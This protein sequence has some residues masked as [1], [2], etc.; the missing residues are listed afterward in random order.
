LFSG[1]KSTWQEPAAVTQIS[2]KGLIVIYRLPVLEQHIGLHCPVQ[3]KTDFT[4]NAVYA[5]T[6]K[7]IATPRAKK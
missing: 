3:P 2:P 7:K 6:D 1:L 5:G 4:K